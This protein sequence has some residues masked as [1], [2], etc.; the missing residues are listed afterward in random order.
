MG[1][2]GRALTVMKRYGERLE[3]GEGGQF[4]GL[5]GSGLTGDICELTR[6]QTVTRPACIWLCRDDNIPAEYVT[7]PVRGARGNY[8]A[9]TR[10]PLYC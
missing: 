6:R 7:R 2:G 8:T 1:H 5:I 4:L 3:H 10:L 9:E